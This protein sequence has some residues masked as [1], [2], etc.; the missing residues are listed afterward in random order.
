MIQRMER[1]IITA[2]LLYLLLAYCV[3]PALW[4]H[5]EHNPALADEPKT[6]TTPEYIPGDPIQ[7][8]TGW[9]SARDHP[10]LPGSRLVARRSESHG[11]PALRSQ[12][13][14]SLGAL[15]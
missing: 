4:R 5:Y 14:C 1:W 11:E 2:V 9:H 3:T 13:V 8:R 6:T 15:I 10:G 12:A 7:C